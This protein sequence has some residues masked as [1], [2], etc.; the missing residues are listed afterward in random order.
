MSLVEV[1]VSMLTALRLRSI[2]RRKDASSWA[3]LISA[4]VRKNASS[5]AMSGSIMP[6]P[7]AIPTIDAYAAVPGRDRG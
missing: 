1:S 2:T 5:V 4:S 7:L 3:R 6:T